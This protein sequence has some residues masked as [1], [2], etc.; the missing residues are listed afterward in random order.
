MKKLSIIIPIYNERKTL[1]K[2]LEKVEKAPTL[3]LKK[4]IVLV[5]DGSTDGGREILK[6]LEKKYLVIYH[7]KNQGKGAAL[8][9][10][11]QKATGDIILIQ[12]ADLE[13]NP[14]NYRRLLQPILENKTDIVYGSRNLKKNPSSYFSYCWGG[15][16]INWLYDVF[17]NS[18]LTDLT[19]CYKVFKAPVLQNLKLKS[20][21]FELEIEITSKALK[22][23]Y[24]ISEVPIDYYPRTI[25]QGKKIRPRDG[26]MLIWQIIR[27]KFY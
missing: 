22:K 2:I 26:L 13:Y 7:S 3:G 25:E 9:S 4:E 21:G 10:G 12:D 23:N 11:F 6:N 24:Q 20:N 18:H 1:L 16:L 19:T 14:Q 27:S 5:D 8:K 17:Y 15:K